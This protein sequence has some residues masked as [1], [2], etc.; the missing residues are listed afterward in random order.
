MKPLPKTHPELEVLENHPISVEYR[1][2]NYRLAKDGSN[3]IRRRNGYSVWDVFLLAGVYSS[4]R[5]LGVL[6]L[7]F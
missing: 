7:S 1:V 6:A 4:W 3:V 2:Y 5:Y